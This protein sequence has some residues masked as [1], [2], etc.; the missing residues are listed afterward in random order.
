VVLRRAITAN[1]LKAVAHEILM[2]QTLLTPRQAQLLDS[3]LQ[4]GTVGAE[5]VRQP[6][7]SS[8]DKK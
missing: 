7:R 3:I 6:L 8:H 2:G 1:G 5:G 4:V